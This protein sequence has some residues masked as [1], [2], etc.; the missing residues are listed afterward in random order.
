MIL[1]QKRE[2]IRVEMECFDRNW[3]SGTFCTER[4]VC[5][6]DNLYGTLRVYV[7][8]PFGGDSLSDLLISQ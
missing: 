8:F 4:N 2:G 6:K 3:F 1:R 5:T 7:G